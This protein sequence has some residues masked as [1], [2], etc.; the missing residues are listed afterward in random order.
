MRVLIKYLSWEAVQPYIKGGTA[1]FLIETS[2]VELRMV[3]SID[4]RVAFSHF[5]LWHNQRQQ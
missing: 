2:V 3:C 1:S 5:L 4:S